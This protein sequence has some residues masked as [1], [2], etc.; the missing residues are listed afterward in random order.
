MVVRQAD[1]APP[2]IANVAGD[3]GAPAAFG[4]A[5]DVGRG[6]PAPAEC[7]D[8]PPSAAGVSEAGAAAGV[9]SVASAPGW[10]PAG[11]VRRGGAALSSAYQPSSPLPLAA[12]LARRHSAGAS[13]AAPLVLLRDQPGV[14]GRTYSSA[15]QAAPGVAPLVHR[16]S[17]VEAGPPIEAHDATVAGRPAQLRHDAPAAE[18]AQAVRAAGIA[19][20]DPVADVRRQRLADDAPDEGRA[21]PHAWISADTSEPEL[22]VGGALTW[23][24][25]APIAPA[26]GLLRRSPALAWEAAMRSAGAAPVPAPSPAGPSS[27][28]A[29]A[30]LPLQRMPPSSG[31]PW[32]AA[33]PGA[34]EGASDAT[35]PDVGWD[36][37]SHTAAGVVGMPLLQRHVAQTPAA[38]ERASVYAGAAAAL[39][40][41]RPAAADVWRAPAAPPESPP[42]PGADTGQPAQDQVGPNIEQIAQKVY[43]HLRRRLLID[44]E[45]RGRPL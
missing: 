13:R 5:A 28:G 26:L 23:P 10:P 42:P 29:G 34:P 21:P 7:D 18:V 12:L 39:E 6:T 27:F 33:R 4:V 22:L 1:H 14:A 11:S 31:A 44:H 17:R 3:P 2:G 45:R 24:G 19:P 43:D 38:S 41:S 40:L 9:G 30:L 32:P 35:P 25:P 20:A 36:M 37:F 16:A 8:W 15:G